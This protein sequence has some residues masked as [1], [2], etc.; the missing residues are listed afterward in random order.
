MTN[1]QRD[2]HSQPDPHDTNLRDRL[3]F[4]GVDDDTRA[5]LKEF[6]PV[7][8]AELPGILARFYE[9]VQRWPAL[10][11]MFK[12]AP[13]MD[14]ARNAQRDH[15]LNLF[16]GRFDQSYVASVRRIGMMHS[17]IGLDPQWYI[18]GY[19]FTLNLLYAA[20]ARVHS[21]RFQPAASQE[22]TGRLMRALNQAAMLDMDLAISIYLEENKASYERRLK[23]LAD[24]FEATVKSVVGAVATAATEMRAS[25]QTLSATA[26]ETSRQAN[27]VSEAVEHASTNVQTMASATE[28]LSASVAEIAR[29]VTESSTITREAV[30]EAENTNATV[31]TLAEIAQKIGDVVKLISEIA[32]Q[33]NLLALNAT[34]EA[35]R[36]GEA[37]KGFAVV[38]SEVKSLANQTARA[39]DDIRAQIEGIQDATG[40]TVTAIGNIGKTIGRLSEIAGVIAAAVE[41]QGAATREIADNARMVAQST[42]EVSGSIKGVTEAS[43]E[44]GSGAGQVLT[45][46]GELSKQSE[47]LRSEVDGFLGALKGA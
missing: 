45:A 19:A 23:E 6:M 2:A 27:A 28:E 4:I 5:A 43:A 40:R 22:R 3:A 14:R 37:G 20:A 33:T 21:N 34:I 30:G 31:Q 39:T 29:Q 25:A 46:A 1:P 16:S 12:G 26:E 15:W 44:T 18:D 10:A 9:H 7:L 42:S 13:A 11:A 41:Q 38:A 17:R 32:G 24:G 36:A 35:A 8:E 47:V